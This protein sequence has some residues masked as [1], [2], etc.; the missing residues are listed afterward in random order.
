MAEI[1]KINA[2]VPGRVAQSVHVTCLAADPGV[3][4]SIP[5][6]SLTF[7]ETD[8]EI[9]ST[10]I[11]PPSADVDSYVHKVLVNRLVNLAQ[12]KVW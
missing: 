5:A 3:A 4:S 11:L 7:A 9:I 12:E 10:A 1:K 6:R 8:H 2:L